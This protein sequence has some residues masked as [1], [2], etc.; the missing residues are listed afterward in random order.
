MVEHHIHDD[1]HTAFVAL[2]DKLLDLRLRTV[3]TVRSEIVVRRIA[4]VV[5]S[6]ELADRHELDSVDAQL[7]DIIQTLH[8]T[9]YIALSSIIIDPQ[10]VNNKVVLVRTLE[11]DRCIRPV[12]CRFLR[13]DNGHVAT[14][15]TNHRVLNQCRV[16]R[17]G[18]ILVILV[19]HLGGKEIRDLLVHRVRTLYRVLETI[20]L[21][22]SQTG[23]RNPEVVS[24]TLELIRRI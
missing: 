20:L 9:F 12:I 18:F 19:N 22:R 13:L 11:I 23:Q 3:S 2:V 16:C 14:V 17:T 8:K 6:V 15:G 24:V 4:P 21:L 10:F 7:L 1:S 5:V